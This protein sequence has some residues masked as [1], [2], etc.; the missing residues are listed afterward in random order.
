MGNRMSLEG[1]DGY[2]THLDYGKPDDTIK[3]QLRGGGAAQASNGKPNH[4]ARRR[5]QRTAIHEDDD[6]LCEISKHAFHNGNS[7]DRSQAY[8]T[9]VIRS[10]SGM[11]SRTTFDFNDDAA[12][13]P[14]LKDQGVRPNYAEQEPAKAEAHQVYGRNSEPVLKVSL[15][16]CTSI[17][18]NIDKVRRFADCHDREL[19]AYLDLRGI[20]RGFLTEI[21]QFLRGHPEIALVPEG[22]IALRDYY[23]LPPLEAYKHFLRGWTKPAR[24]VCVARAIKR[25]L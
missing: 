11:S 21:D 20:A 8:H 5:A 25:E 4:A 18:T 12:P 13:N 19:L 10:A 22:R 1:R 15:L 3:A 7:N 9:P 23:T 14:W 6:E 2:P 16:I 24:Y 17:S